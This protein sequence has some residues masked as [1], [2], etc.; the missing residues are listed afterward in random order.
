MK[1]LHWVILLFQAIFISHTWAWT[2]PPRHTTTTE[3]P[4]TETIAVALAG[5]PTPANDT[6][7]HPSVLPAPYYHANSSR[8][9]DHIV[10]RLWGAAEWRSYRRSPFGPLPA[11][12]KWNRVDFWT[13]PLLDP[14][15]LVDGAKVPCRA[16]GEQFSQVTRCVCTAWR[17]APHKHWICT[18]EAL[19]KPSGDGPM[20]EKLT[21]SMK[22]RPFGPHRLRRFEKTGL[23]ANFK[24]YDFEWKR[25]CVGPSEACRH[26]HVK[27]FYIA[28]RKVPVHQPPAALGMG[29][30]VPSDWTPDLPEGAL[31]GE[32]L[33][34]VE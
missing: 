31:D 19:V 29:T 17:S 22:G 2:P 34:T 1:S 32:E 6:I 14:H 9:N 20:P 30:V 27:T 4:P 28:G 33:D 24:V 11:R 18:M 21:I 12:G 5:E 25:D 15:K 3:L 26:Q 13:R 10:T 16:Y 23:V 7:N 8:V